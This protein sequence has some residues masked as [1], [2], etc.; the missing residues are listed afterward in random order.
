MSISY[1]ASLSKVQNTRFGGLIAVMGGREPY[2]YILDGLK[3]SG[4]VEYVDGQIRLTPAGVCE[5]DRLATLAGLMVQKDEANI[6][7][8]DSR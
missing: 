1:M 8:R 4:F 3:E 5:K 6:L 7:P 2:D